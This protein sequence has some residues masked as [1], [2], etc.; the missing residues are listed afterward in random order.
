MD[1][2]ILNLTNTRSSK[3]VWYFFFFELCAT[4]LMFDYTRCIGIHVLSTTKCVYLRGITTY[5]GCPGPI[6]REYHT[7]RDGRGFCEGFIIRY[8]RFFFMY[9]LMKITKIENVT[10]TNI[11]NNL[12]NVYTL[13]GTP[14]RRY[15][16]IRT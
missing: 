6:S 2:Y 15:H 10:S 11:S 5:C 4:W 3:S 12:E 13:Y 16:I 1:F 9:M 8:E 14:R 7:Q